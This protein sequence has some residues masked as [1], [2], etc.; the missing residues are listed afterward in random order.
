MKQ[1]LSMLRR[2]RSIWSIKNE[3]LAQSREAMLAAVQIYNNPLI[4][5]KSESFIVLSNIAWTYLLHAYYRSEG[6]DY[7][8][9]KT[10]GKRK[11]Y[12]RTKNG[13]HKHWELQ[14]CIDC[15]K[16]PLDPATS[17][18]L[19][20]LIGI[21]HEIEHRMSVYVDDAIRGKIQS[22]CINY[23]YY[24]KIL[25]GAK[26][27]VD[28]ELGFSVQ[29]T[30]L[31]PTQTKLL[32]NNERL[33]IN[34][35][36]Y[37]VDFEKSC[38]PEEVT[39]IHYEYRIQFTGYISSKSK[40]DEIITFQKL[41]EDTH[42]THPIFI[43]EVEKKKYYPKEIVELMHERGYTEFNMNEFINL[44]K[45]KNAR[46]NSDYSVNLGGRWAWYET[47]VENV[48]KHCSKKYGHESDDNYPSS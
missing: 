35:R 17:A 9:Y 45:E 7:R 36:N 11:R 19:R 37:I 23:N 1:S 32:T 27:G 42:G 44:W 6:V 34:I 30:E 24:I 20:F 14:R 4:T 15:D 10:Q 3:L 22:C 39:G 48:E 25:F 31:S 8:W 40:A 43:R 33:P 18:N 16:S 12:D 38:K 2:P 47:W 29:F 5:F 46:G 13:A 26:F 41:S 21:R 28:S